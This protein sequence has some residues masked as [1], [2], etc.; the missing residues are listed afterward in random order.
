MSEALRVA[1]SLQLEIPT[2]GRV[3]LG[4]LEAGFEAAWKV[5][6]KIVST[7]KVPRISTALHD[8]LPYV[9]TASYEILER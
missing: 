3:S 1:V 6:S 7:K 2:K 9:H 5:F 8:L 4:E